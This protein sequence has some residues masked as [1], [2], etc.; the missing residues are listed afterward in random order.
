MT[1]EQR[2]QIINEKSSSWVNKKLMEKLP[3]Y[4]IMNVHLAMISGKLEKLRKSSS[5]KLFMPSIKIVFADPDCES[6]KCAF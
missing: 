5:S 2:L 3:T 4:Q 1:T 6:S